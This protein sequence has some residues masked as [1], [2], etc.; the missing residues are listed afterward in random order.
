VFLSAALLMAIALVVSLF[1]TEIPLRRRRT[2]H[3]DGDGV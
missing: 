2:L 1:L 3:D